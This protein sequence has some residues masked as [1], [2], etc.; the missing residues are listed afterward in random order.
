M[1]EEEVRGFIDEGYEKAKKIITD[2]I[3]DLH[4][5]AKALLEYE[6]LSGDE[7]K[8]LLRGEP[9][10]RDDPDVQIGDAGRSSVPSGGG[11]DV[12]A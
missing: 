4:I 8:G 1:I 11:E 12:T 3:D 10:I 5:I 6:L 2:H 9:I 7:I